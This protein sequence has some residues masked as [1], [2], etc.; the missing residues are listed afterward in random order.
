M[1]RNPGGRRA[2]GLVLRELRQARELTQEGLAAAAGFDRTYIG[3]V[4]R[5]EK[6]PTFEML[7]RVL[8]ALGVS[9]ADFG[10]ALDA[11][12]AIQRGPKAA[13]PAKTARPP[14]QGARG[15]AAG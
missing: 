6:S 12:P 7:W 9:W 11:Q 14:R 2:L 5:A 3:Q 8:D 15:G 10:R 13:A 1:N 4:E